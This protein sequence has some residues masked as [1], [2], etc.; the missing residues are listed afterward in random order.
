VWAIPEPKRTEVARFNK[1]LCQFGERYFMRCV[2]EIPFS[3]QDG[4][5]GWGAWA[6]VEW[7]TFER[8]LEMYES[9]GCEEPLH[10][11]ALANALPAYPGSFGN[12][13]LIQFRES[14]KRPSLLSLP[15]DPSVLAM[16]QRHGIDNLRFH[17][18]TERFSADQ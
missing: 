12:P 3:D 17:E 2:L 18:I 4:F 11:G 6:E 13:V 15:N 1:D 10:K 5:F 14:T 8:Y 16:E 9:D 7:S